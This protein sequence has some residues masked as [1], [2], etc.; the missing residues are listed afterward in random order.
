MTS[1]LDLVIS[2]LDMSPL[3]LTGIPSAPSFRSISDL[4]NSTDTIIH[5]PVIAAYLDHT[6]SVVP[7]SD[8][9]A[10]L[11]L[12]MSTSYCVEHSYGTTTPVAD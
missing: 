12:G 8:T 4:E 6:H 11:A 7:S 3:Y 1:H 2:F 10:S 5:N 9:T